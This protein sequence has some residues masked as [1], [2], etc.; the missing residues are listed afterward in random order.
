MIRVWTQVI[1]RVIAIILALAVVV[2]LLYLLR[3]LLLL[4][5]LSISFCYLIAPL[6]RLFQQPVYL[7]GREIRMPRSAAI[8][9]VYFLIAAV[10]YFGTRLIW[11]QVSDQFGELR[12]NWDAYLKSGSEA[13]NELVTGANTWMR[14]LRLPQGW[15]DYLT[16]HVAELAKSAV[17]WIESIVGAVVGYLPY[18]SWLV[19]VPILSFFLLRD[20]ESFARTTVELLP[21]ERLRKRAHWLLMDVSNTMAAYIRAQITSCIAVGTIATPFLYLFG[22]PYAALLGLVIAICEIVPMVGPLIGACIAVAISFTVSVKTALLVAAFLII[23]RLFQDYLIYPKIVGHG[24]KMH[25]LLVILAIFGGWEVGGLIGIFLA[26]PVIGLIIVA[27]HHY[28]AY[29]GIQSLK[30]VVPGDELEQPADVRLADSGVRG[31]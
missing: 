2:W 30:I 3:T 5:L 24:I 10:L 29:R 21:N 14:R 8:G 31:D 18:L 4:L 6:V 9:F 16:E 12:R 13:A 28:V 20:G 1:L 7:G 23:L 17:P 27:Y 26:I 19:L 22:A 25:P 11:P 15:R